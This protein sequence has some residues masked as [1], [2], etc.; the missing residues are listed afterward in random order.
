MLLNFQAERAII[1]IGK[2]NWIKKTILNE[3][4]YELNKAIEFEGNIHWIYKKKDVTIEHN[5][6][7]K[8]T[9][10]LADIDKKRLPF[11]I[12]YI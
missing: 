10:D 12:E 3:T 11:G 6:M 9:F 1:R 5:Q 4:H 2:E 7:I 8:L